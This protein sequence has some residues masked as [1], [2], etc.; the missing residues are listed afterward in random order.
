MDNVAD[1]VKG[2]FENVGLNIE[3]DFYYK[4]S[5]N[6]ID[7]KTIENTNDLCN[8]IL[9]MIDITSSKGSFYINISIDTRLYN[10]SVVVLIKEYL[11]KHGFLVV[12]F[13]VGEDKNYL[14]WSISWGH[15]GGVDNDR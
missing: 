8:K 11:K 2:A 7:T 5:V 13:G 12:S 9:H 4:K 6:A 3:A 15:L 1:L 10:D 14:R